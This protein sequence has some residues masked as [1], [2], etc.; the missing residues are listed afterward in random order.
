MESAIPSSRSSSR[1]D[2]ATWVWPVLLLTALYVVA[3]R[4]A[5]ELTYYDDKVTLVVWPPAG[6]SLAALILFGR[7]LWPG[8]F[9]GALLVNLGIPFG[10]ISSVGIAIGDTLEALVSVTLLIRVA[11][12]RPTLERMR[13]GVSFLLISVVGC[14][15]ISTTIGTVSVLLLGGMGA[16]RFWLVWP[17]WWL[18][19]AGGVL[20]V[21]PVLLMLARGTP[22]WRSL[23]RRLESWLALAF[24]PGPLP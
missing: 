24:R 21:T 1:V 15:T 9:I 17:V 3:G 5:L 2:L 11:D 19:T 18:G 12:F 8:V 6:L 7:R 16:D 14:T 4:L 10:W 13:D 22:S 23:A 20:V